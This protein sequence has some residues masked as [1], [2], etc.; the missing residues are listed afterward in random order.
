MFGFCGVKL[1]LTA[2][3]VTKMLLLLLLVVEFP[4]MPCGRVF[5]VQVL[6]LRVAVGMGVL[7]SM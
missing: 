4:S 5:S 3:G 1:P 2:Y 7:G 6:V